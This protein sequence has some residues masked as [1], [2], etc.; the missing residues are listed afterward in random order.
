MKP[1]SDPTLLKA[2]EGASRPAADGGAPEGLKPVNDPL[3]R[4]ALEGAATPG[5]L[6]GDLVP[7][8]GEAPKSTAAKFVRQVGLTGRYALEGVPQVL[9][10]LDSPIRAVQEIV[11]GR[12]VPTAGGEGGLGSQLADWLGLPK[13]ETPQE[14][15]V[16]DATRTGFGAAGG[17]AAAG[18][19]VQ[20]ARNLVV[21]APTARLT[22]V[23]GEVSKSL[24]ANT[25]TQA[26]SGAAAGGASGEVRESGGSPLG[27]AIAA[28][29]AGVAAPLAAGK[30]A[31]VA[32][33]TTAAVR[34]R[35]Q[36]QQL[37]A[38]LQAELGRAGIDWGQLGADVKL[39]LRQ[40]AAKAVYSGQPLNTDAL[41]R[42]ADYRTIGATPLVG[43]ITQDPQLLTL[44]RNL[45]KQLAN[46][47]NPVAKDGLPQ[48]QNR[49]AQ[50]VLSTLENAA[51]SPLDTHDTGER[52]IGM[53]QGKDAGMGVAE[54]ALYL[55]ARDADGRYIPLAR[56][57]FVN[58]AFANLAKSNKT[59]FLPDDIAKMLNQISVGKVTVGGHMG[60]GGTDYP[61]PFDVSTIDML[62]TTLAAASRQAERA[63][64]GNAKA[65][66]A[67]VRDALENTQ[68][69]P[70]K[71]T[72]GGG[73]VVTGATAQRMQGADDSAAQAMQWFDKARTAARERRTWQESAPFIDDALGGASPDA[74]V[75]KHVIGA[76]VDDLAKLRRE[77]GEPGISGSRA[78]STEVRD[79]AA[80][81]AQQ[82]GELLGAVRKQLLDYILQR[83]RAD[84]DVVTF[85]S[86]GLKDGLKAIGDRKLALFFSP[87]E[88]QQ[89]KSAVN[90][91]RYMQS[92]PIGS[93]VNNSNSAA[94]LMGK[95]S[96]LLLKG[97][98]IPGIQLAAD[99]L[100]NLTLRAQSVPLSNLSAGLVQPQAAGP[101]PRAA[102]VPLASLLAAPTVDQREDAGRR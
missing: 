71:A 35:L 88:I 83:G 72:F 8:Q 55:R 21:Q 60:H 82:S 57:D 50:R 73:Q 56:G 43:D 63:G 62:K 12:R 53:V 97:S 89:I 45:T 54:N 27:Q 5:G 64:N 10:V 39:Q 14:R 33:A 3:L 26:L 42:L 1:I 67:A 59:A 6:F 24:A 44:Q 61:V 93:A 98:N 11:T 65:A 75:R 19:P 92:Q 17:A 78:L 20:V 94:M 102:L 18:A 96:D 15:V 101:G 30:A 25:G 13:P 46:I 76:S 86:A 37:D 87:E 69:E 28:T 58:Q 48:L 47:S 4:K 81:A 91:G 52:L 9:D 31:G 23:A 90:V 77:I 38:V 70:I 41:R 68:P 85:S 40:D 34:Q 80:P 66:I 49:N 74:F 16:A 95:L 100:R 7:A 32:R 84:S 51:D 99:P 22:G 2:L 29:A 36:P 79:G